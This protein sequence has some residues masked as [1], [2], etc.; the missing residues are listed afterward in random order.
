M[1]NKN[2]TEEKTSCERDVNY[3]ARTCIRVESLD[4][5]G[6]AD[7][8]PRTQQKAFLRNMQLSNRTSAPAVRQVGKT[9]ALMV[10]A[11]WEAIFKAGR[12]ILFVSHNVDYGKRTNQRMRDII[13]QMPLW[14]KPNIENHTKSEITFSNGSKIIFA[15]TLSN[16]VKGYE[17]DTVLVDDFP[18][19]QNSKD[20]F[21]VT[22]STISSKTEGKYVVTGTPQEMFDTFF[23]V[24]IEFGKE[25]CIP[26]PLS[27]AI[28]NN[29]AREDELRKLMSPEQ[30]S[31]EFELSFTL[32]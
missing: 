10:F 7:F 11:L 32:K 9:T 16:S 15:S 20:F 27:D 17:I 30:F 23:N 13:E 19:C 1:I 2:S 28:K 18:L 31:R 8:E 6:F 12:T 24:I 22:Y 4:H 14:V 29:K 21:D 26:I 5:G 3:F 25:N